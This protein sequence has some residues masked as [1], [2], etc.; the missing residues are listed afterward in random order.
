MPVRPAQHSYSDSGVH[1]DLRAPRVRAALNAQP[2]LASRI[3]TPSEPGLVDQSLPFW[4]SNGAAGLSGSSFFL[5]AV[6]SLLSFL[7]GFAVL[8]W[9]AVAVC[10]FAFSSFG[11]S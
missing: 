8:F 2:E 7:A 9:A 6:L 5:G 3:S 1:H 4:G 10:G 11:L